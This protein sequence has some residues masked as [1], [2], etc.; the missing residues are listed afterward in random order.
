MRSIFRSLQNSGALNFN[1]LENDTTL[2]LE[3]YSD[4]KS[5][6]LD[7]RTRALPH[8]AMPYAF[9]NDLTFAGLK[10]AI[11]QY[12]GVILLIRVGSEFWT[13]K[14]GH[15]SWEEA[16]ILPLRTPKSIVSGHFVVAHSFDKDNIYFANSFSDDW[17]RKGH[18]YFKEDYMPF[19]IQAGATVDVPDTPDPT[20]TFTRQLDLGM[21]G[22]D[23]QELQKLLKKLGFFPD[24]QP[25]TLYFGAITQGAL[26]KYQ[27][28]RGIACAGTPGTTGYGRVGPKTITALNNEK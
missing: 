7:M 14:N 21:S 13:D 18:G 8:V 6:T 28:A 26:K 27:C 1:L 23:V 11:Y 16:D 17:G 15:T 3:K 20:Y 5:V 25:T 24:A 9:V 12:K 19:V 4:R 10:R 2:S 22:A